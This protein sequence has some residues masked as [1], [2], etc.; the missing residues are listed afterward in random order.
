MKTIVYCI[1]YKSFSQMFQTIFCKKY[2][3][4]IVIIEINSS[5]N[6]NNNN[7]I[8]QPPKYNGTGFRA[9]F[10]LGLEKGYRFVLEMIYL[11]N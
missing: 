6:T 4:K 3:P 8:H 2:N 7:Y 5:V 11:I 1:D 10:N 9:T